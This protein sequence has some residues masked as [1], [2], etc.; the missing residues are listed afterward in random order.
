[1][2][3]DFNAT[4]LQLFYF[5]IVKILKSCKLTSRARVSQLVLG[6]RSGCTL[7]LASS[8][9]QTRAA[10]TTISSDAARFE[11]L[12]NNMCHNFGQNTICWYILFQ[13]AR[14]MGLDG[15]EIK[16][17]CNKRWD[18]TTATNYFVEIFGP[19]NVEIFGSID[20]EIFG[21]INIEIFGFTNSMSITQVHPVHRF[22][23]QQAMEGR[24]RK[25]SNY[26]RNILSGI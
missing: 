2:L 11:H 13:A 16:S 9:P 4:N 10:A 17:C 20:I 7:A 14:D 21:S 18:L 22:C 23:K 12:H 24:S 6:L 1:M 15:S 26:L 19:L 8:E 25:V 5:T 3:Q